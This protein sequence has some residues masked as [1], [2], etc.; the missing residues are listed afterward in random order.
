MLYVVGDLF[1]QGSPLLLFF[2]FPF[3]GGG[4]RLSDRLAGQEEGD[5]QDPCDS[6]RDVHPEDTRDAECP[7]DRR[8]DQAG[9]ERAEIHQRI[10]HRVAHGGCLCR[11]E[12]SYRGIAS[13]LVD[14]VSKDNSEQSS[15]GD[16]VRRGPEPR[17]SHLRAQCQ[18][19]PAEKHK[20]EREQECLAGADEVDR[21]AQEQHAESD[22]CSQE[23][24]H[25]IGADIVQ[26]D[27]LVEENREQTDHTEIRQAFQ[28]IREI[29]APQ[30]LRGVN[31]IDER[32]ADLQD[33]FPKDGG[34]RVAVFRRILLHG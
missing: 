23:S 26:T 3:C 17:C 24:H 19:H 9:D 5:H 4:L 34:L 30:R 31:K 1:L 25:L 13:R 11:R 21:C 14:A 22:S 33:C 12:L 7:P 10:K 27:A 15:H 32:L 16:E 8:R 18:R 2:F 28:E 20:D 6:Q 29:D